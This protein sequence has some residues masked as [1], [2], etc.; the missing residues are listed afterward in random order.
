MNFSWDLIH[1]F[2]AVAKTGSLLAAA[3][4]LGLSQPT[5]GRHIDTLEQALNV[6]LFK[7]SRDGMALTDAGANLVASSDEMKRTATEFHRKASGQDR[8][9]SGTVRL[10]VNDI[11]GVYVLPGMLKEFTDRYPEIE[12]EL[13]ISNAAANLLARDADVALRM[14]RPT[15]NDLIARKVVEI[16]VGFYAHRSYIASRGQPLGLED[17]S[18]HSF[19]GFDRERY[20]I[21]AGKSFGLKLTPS[22]FSFRCDNIPAQVE[23][24]RVGMGIGILHQGL[25]AN[26]EGV[27]RLLAEITL[28]PIEIWLAWHSDLRHNARI[29]LLVD[30]LAD[31]LR[32]PYGNTN[33]AKS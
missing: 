27:E 7:R 29:R 14:F 13:D 21:D 4:R 25:A 19:I 26:M 3:K 17:L 6:T 32:R 20:H 10:S 8:G 22:D 1:T 15:Q 30:F 18:E 5:V 11:L 33:D 2:D 23:A 24:T 28:P 31:R 16:P 9:I 12:V